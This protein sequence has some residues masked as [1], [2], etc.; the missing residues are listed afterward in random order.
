MSVQWGVEYIARPIAR[1]RTLAERL[2]ASENIDLIV[3]SHA[4]VLQPI[5]R[6]GDKYV[7]YG[8]GN[9]LTNQSPLSCQSCP[10]STTD[11]VIV[12]VEVAETPDG[13]IEVAGVSAIPTWV[14]RRTFTITDVGAVLA[15]DLG[16]NTRR[17]FERS[18]KRT[19]S[20]LRAFDVE[21]AVKGD[22][23]ASP[24]DAGAGSSSS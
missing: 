4:H 6:V 19:A 9:F 5:G 14:D 8:L 17:Q 23:D 16:P 12:G 7:I 22:P 10:E 21:I 3:G 11:G 15:G 13:R 18:W 2:L 24:D 1:Q 20:T